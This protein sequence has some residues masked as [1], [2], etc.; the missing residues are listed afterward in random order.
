MRK[1]Y[2]I[3]SFAFYLN[4]CLKGSEVRKLTIREKRANYI[5]RS[6]SKY[7]ATRFL[8]EVYCGCKPCLYRQ[9][10]GERNSFPFFVF[11]RKLTTQVIKKKGESVS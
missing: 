8:V 6:Q 4:Y 10:W 11:L 9:G 7:S 1:E 2:K 5:Y 3:P